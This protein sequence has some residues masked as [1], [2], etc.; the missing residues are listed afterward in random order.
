MVERRGRRRRAIFV[1]QAVIEPRQDPD[2]GNTGRSF[3]LLRRLP[4]Q[5]RITME[6]IEYETCEQRSFVRTNETPCAVQVS[7]GTASDDVDAQKDSRNDRD[8]RASNRPIGIAHGLYLR[9]L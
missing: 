8:I 5:R 1:G 3:E 7:K 6:L 9:E 2:S 4:E